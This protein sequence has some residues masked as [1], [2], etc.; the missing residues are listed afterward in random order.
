MR[1]HACIRTGDIGLFKIIYEGSISAGVRRIEAIT[2]EGALEKFQEATAQLAKAGELLRTS[3]TGVLDQLEKFLE[4]QKILERQ[5]E[6]LKTKMAH[7]QV[8][9]LKGR[10]V[11]GATVLAERVEGLIQSNCERSPIRSAIS[12]AA[13]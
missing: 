2:G 7:Q 5:L 9:N 13:R 10:H 3:D 4:H 8:E 12:G 6:Q 11:N 1:R